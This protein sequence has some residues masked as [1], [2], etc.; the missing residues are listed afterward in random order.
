M[1]YEYSTDS[2]KMSPVQGGVK[3]WYAYD[4]RDKNGFDD[5]PSHDGSTPITRYRIYGSASRGANKSLVG[6]L[7]MP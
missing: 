2:N 1:T 7:S 3:T 4:F 6:S 5:P